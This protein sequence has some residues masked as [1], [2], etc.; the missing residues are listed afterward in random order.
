LVPA[1]R[2]VHSTD[3]VSGLD[4]LSFESVVIPRGMAVDE[5]LVDHLSQMCLAEENDAIGGF[6]LE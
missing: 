3:F 4:D 5:I 2:P 6:S 1:D